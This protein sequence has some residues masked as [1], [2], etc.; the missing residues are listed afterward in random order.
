M[1]KVTG[2]GVI[3]DT[4]DRAKKYADMYDKDLVEVADG[5]LAKNRTNSAQPM[6]TKEGDVVIFH[7][8]Q[9]YRVWVT[10]WDGAQGPD[11]DV[12]PQE[13]WNAG[14]A[15][16]AAIDWAGE[17]R[18][19]IYRLGKDGNW[20]AKPKLTTRMKRCTSV[21]LEPLGLSDQRRPVP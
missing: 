20:S 2:R 7:L 9:L 6:P 8:H 16:K 13:F 11:P 3:F 4:K 1:A 5:W 12:S 15:E 17:T 18:G 19:Q 10:T 21:S 14:E